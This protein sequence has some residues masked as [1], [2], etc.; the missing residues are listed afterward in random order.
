MLYSCNLYNIIHQLHF[1]LKKIEILCCV[2][3]Q[4]VSHVQ[5]FATPGTAAC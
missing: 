3:V 4:S 1:N 2:V 5:L